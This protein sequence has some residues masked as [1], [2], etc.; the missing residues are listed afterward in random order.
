MA[1]PYFYPV[2]RL[3]GREWAVAPRLPLGDAYGGECRA[4]GEPF[5]PDE[6][7]ERRTCNAGYGREGCGHFPAESEADAV[8]F[9]ILL[10]SGP[11]LRIQFVIEKGWWPLRHGVMEYSSTEKIVTDPS[12]DPILERQASAFAESYL[13]RRDS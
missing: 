6:E 10:D 13:R 7:F 8:R 3:D 12:F 2:A 1:C 9:H 11:S 4:P 5:Q